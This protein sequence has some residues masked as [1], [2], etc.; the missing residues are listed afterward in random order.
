MRTPH[1]ALATCLLGLAVVG[2]T[3]TPGAPDD[4]LPGVA[5]PTVEPAGRPADHAAGTMVDYLNAARALAGLPPLRPV[6]RLT[7]VAQDRADRMAESGWPEH[8][9]MLPDGDT[10][11]AVL[12]LH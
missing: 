3:A 4:R 10:F 11:D 6:A 9:H 7:A 1:R 2:C 8:G 5:A 12:L